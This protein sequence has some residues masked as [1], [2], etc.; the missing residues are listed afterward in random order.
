MALT[1]EEFNRDV[2]SLVER[3]SIAKG[4]ANDRI[5]VLMDWQVAHGPC[6][7][8]Y[9]VHPPVTT[10]ASLD[11]HSS[12][13]DFGIFLEDENVILDPETINLPTPSTTTISG[14]TTTLEWRF[15]IVYSHT[16]QVPLLYFTVQ[17][18]DGSPC[19]R[20]FILHVL[21][22]DV[23]E[24]YDFISYDEH[25]VTGRPSFYLHPCQ[26][27]ARMSL[28]STTTGT[29]AFPFHFILSWLSLVLPAVGFQIP[30]LL[31]SPAC[32]K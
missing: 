28:L 14:I 12:E 4:I 9:L 8:L 5:E 6:E 32:I 11:H 30:S 25:P 26:T 18:M 15:S 23:D 17:Y 19:L 13:H 29:C 3:L 10:S 22:A 1:R 24:S 16:W 20:S 31:F 7:M 21:G 2:N 27:A